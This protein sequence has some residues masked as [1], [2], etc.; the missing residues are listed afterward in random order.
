[1]QRTSM[2]GTSMCLLSKNETN[3]IQIYERKTENEN[4]QN[5]TRS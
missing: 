5:S 4:L 2:Q 3:I 1:M